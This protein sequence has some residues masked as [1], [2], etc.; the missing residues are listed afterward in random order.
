MN[1]IYVFAAF[2]IGAYVL[3]AIFGMKQ[4]KHF[5]TVYQRLRR[6][7]KVAIGRRS[8]RFKAGTI[9]MFAVDE[10]GQILDARKMQG[11]SVLAKF[12]TLEKYIG[13]DIHYLDKYHPQVRKENKLMRLAM[14][15]AREIYLRVEVG[16]YKE[17]QAVSPLMGA[18]VQLQL[19][20]NQLQT[21]MKRSVK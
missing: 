8:G 14:E 12:H 9:V 18:T 20:K 1:F 21:R 2:A 4:I 3:Q 5:N 10:T 6:Q 16:N 17:E 19:W 13:E 15:N 7:G 11:V